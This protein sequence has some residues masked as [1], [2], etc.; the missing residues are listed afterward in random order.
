[1]DVAASLLI[2]NDFMKAGSPDMPRAAG[3]TGYRAGNDPKGVYIF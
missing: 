3:V 1:M 2:D